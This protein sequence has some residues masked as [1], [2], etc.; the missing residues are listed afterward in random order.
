M[1][2]GNAAGFVGNL[3]EMGP[4][5]VAVAEVTGEGAVEETKNGARWR[6]REEDGCA[7]KED[8]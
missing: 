1:Y 3:R 5:K 2:T 6:R 8:R 7:W 4:L